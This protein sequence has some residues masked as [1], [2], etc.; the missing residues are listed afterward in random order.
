MALLIVALTLL[1]NLRLKAIRTYFICGDV[2]R[3]TVFGLLTY[4]KSFLILIAIVYVV[5]ILLLLGKK[6]L[7]FAFFILAATAVIVWFA[8]V[9]GRLSASDHLSSFHISKTWMN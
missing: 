3:F 5:Y 9:N 2:F 1:I 4:S 7:L 8:L 6:R